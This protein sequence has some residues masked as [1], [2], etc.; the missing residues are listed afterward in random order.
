MYNKMSELSQDP[1]LKDKCQ[2]SNGLSEGLKIYLGPF[3]FT[4][5]LDPPQ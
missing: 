3:L 2:D 5:F 4:I 1:P